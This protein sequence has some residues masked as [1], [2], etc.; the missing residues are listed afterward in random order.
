MRGG[1]TIISCGGHKCELSHAMNNYKDFLFNR[2]S[3]TKLVKE[4][5]KTDREHCQENL[6]NLP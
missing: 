3:I 6:F 5:F 2:R 4:L 1:V